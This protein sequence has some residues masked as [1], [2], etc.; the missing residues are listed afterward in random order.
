MIQFECI[1]QNKSAARICKYKQRMIQ[2]ECIEQNKSAARIC[3]CKQR[4][5]QFECIEQTNLQLEYA[6]IN[7]LKAVPTLS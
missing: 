2:F 3:K 4:M 7:G 6:N 5:I 1:E